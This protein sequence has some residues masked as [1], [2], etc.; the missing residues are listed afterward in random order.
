MELASAVVE[1][2]LSTD[3]EWRHN[4]SSVPFQNTQIS[5]HGIGCTYET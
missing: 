1:S 3:N 2:D 4:I 5:L